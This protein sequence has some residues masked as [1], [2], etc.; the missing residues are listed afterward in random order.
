MKSKPLIVIIEDNPADVQLFRLALQQAELDC[1]LVILRDGGEALAWV[2]D[3]ATGAQQPVPDLAVI[4]LN[5][6][7]ND[8]LEILSAM[9]GNPALKELPSIVLSSSPSP[10]DVARVSTF[11]NAVYSRKPSHLDQ[12][13]DL[14]DRVKRMLQA[15]RGKPLS[16]ST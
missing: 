5:L 9:A 12:Y 16:A 11:P 10:R 15:A 3:H 14:G 4:D 8:G 7:K 13:A 1:E 2:R 6:P